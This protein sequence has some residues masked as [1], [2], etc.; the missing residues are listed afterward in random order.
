MLTTLFRAATVCTRSEGAMVKL[1]C[2]KESSINETSK[3]LSGR[4]ANIA[5]RQDL[6]HVISVPFQEAYR[7][8]TT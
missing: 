3:T 7:T 6:F 2:A 4:A 8:S 1:D 5:D